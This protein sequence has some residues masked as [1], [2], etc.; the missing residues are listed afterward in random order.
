MDFFESSPDSA[1]MHYNL[2]NAL[3]PKRNRNAAIACD[4]TALGVQPDYAAA[5][6]QLRRLGAP[7]P[8]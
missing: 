6:Q 2:G 1:P 7:V 5:K 8:Q 4:Q 3:M